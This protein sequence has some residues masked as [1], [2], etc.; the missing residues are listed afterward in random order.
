MLF[1]LDI[2]HEDHPPEDSACVLGE[3]PLLGG[4]LSGLNSLSPLLCLP[5]LFP[6]HPHLPHP[7]HQVRLQ[8]VDTHGWCARQRR[9]SF[10]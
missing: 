9:G 2:H 3:V 5:L 8:G 4:N 10:G 1:D 7:P 6:K